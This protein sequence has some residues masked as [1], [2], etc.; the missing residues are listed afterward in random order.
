MA[1][2]T[3]QQGDWL[4]RM[5][6]PNWKK[7]ALFMFLLLSFTL[8]SIPDGV[9]SIN[10]NERTQSIVTFATIAYIPLYFLACVIVF[11]LDSV[12]RMTNVKKMS[13]REF[14]RGVGG[15]EEE[16]ATEVFGISFRNITFI[17]I[18]MTAA[19]FTCYICYFKPYIDSPRLDLILNI[20]LAAPMVAFII[21]TVFG[22]G[23]LPTTNK[24]N[25]FIN[26][27]LLLI[28][29]LLLPVT[30]YLIMIVLLL[31]SVFLMT[32]GESNWCVGP[33]SVYLR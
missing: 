23:F 8:N 2:E 25:I 30:R 3:V 19:V 26:D 10:A 21:L 7:G 31:V 13:L 20:M 24:A 17:L 14:M 27:I 18:I 9:F 33:L 5:V 29:R 6:Q 32:K 1:D 12:E 22:G 28:S 11:A 15:E 16:L 4:I